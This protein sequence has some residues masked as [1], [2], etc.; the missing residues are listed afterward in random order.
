MRYF[1]LTILMLASTAA[2]FGQCGSAGHLVLNPITG[3]LDC[4]ANT[5]IPPSGAAGGVLSGT[6]PNPAFKNSLTTNTVTKANSSGEL[7]DSLVTDDGTTISA[8]G[9]FSIKANP[10]ILELPNSATGTTNNKLAKVVNT[11]GVL[12]AEIITTSSTDQVAALGCVIS[13][14]G[15]TGTALIMVFGTGSCF[16]DAAT[17]AG[18]IAVPSSTSAGALHDSGSSSSPT[19]GEVVATVG[20]TNACG[21]PPCL[22]AGNLFMT[23]DLVAQ[24]AQGNGGGNGNGPP[25]KVTVQQTR[26]V[27]SMVIGADNA[28][29]VLVDADI[30][31]QG[32]QCKVP[33]AA[34]VVEIDVNADA[35]TPNVIV[36]KK[37]CNTFTT[38]VCSSWTS[39]DLLS[40]ALAAAASNFDA[41]SKTT[42]V[43]GLDGGTTCSATLQNASIASGDWI[44]LKS[45]TA[46]GTAKRLSVDVIFTV[47]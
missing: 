19:T 17:T 36:R 23:P 29:A 13:G 27:C 18:H 33:Y 9:R 12:Q 14:G 26:R 6:Y 28:S 37:H 2:V 34:T 11:A 16:F 40:G 38:G 30:G 24:G 46:G 35:G 43:A 47:D 15:T 20:A 10:F 1:I 45:G 5:G 21:S 39:T 4:T 42:A 32:Q 41:C 8:G 31:P 3:V 22:I 25:N 44:E 7:A